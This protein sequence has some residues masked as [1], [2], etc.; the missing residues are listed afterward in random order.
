MKKFLDVTM[1]ERKEAVVEKEYKKPAYDWRFENSISNGKKIELDGDYSQWRVNSIVAGYDGCA[2][3]VNEMNI[4]YNVTDQMHYDYL[5]GSVRKMKRYG[6]KKTDQDKRQEQ[7]EKKKEA[8][9]T[10]I[11][12][13][14]K[15][16]KLR[17]KEALKI[18]TAEQIEYIKQKQEKGGVS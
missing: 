12:C 9:I 10:L 14:Y 8:L 16:N 15:Y 4:R 5:F 1:Q 11:S 13:Y 6:K 17:A 2:P 7:E 18:L 3:I